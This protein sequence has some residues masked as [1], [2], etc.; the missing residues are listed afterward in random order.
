MVVALVVCVVRWSAV[1][2]V[3][4]GNAVLADIAVVA[5]AL[6][7][8]EKA[9]SIPSGL[10]HPKVDQEQSSRQQCKQEGGG[11]PVG[12]AR[13]AEPKGGPRG[14]LT[15]GMGSAGG[16]PEVRVEGWGRGGRAWRAGGSS[17]EASPGSGLRAA[18]G[19][20]LGAASRTRARGLCC[21]QTVNRAR[22]R[23]RLHGFVRVRFFFGAS[24]HG[25]RG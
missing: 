13:P 3:N 22:S 11:R 18:R 15:A 19:E 17:Q 10:P 23:A 16:V 12:E 20:D 24:Q 5:L 25:G 7:G 2:A 14:G 8:L 9:M 1:N 4:A 6:R 21:R